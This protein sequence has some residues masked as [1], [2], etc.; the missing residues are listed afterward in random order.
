VDFSW[1]FHITFWQ[2][3]VLLYMLSVLYLLFQ[4]NYP[5]EGREGQAMSSAM[6]IYQSLS[7]WPWVIFFHH[8]SDQET[9]PE[10]RS[11]LPIGGFGANALSQQPW[12]ATETRVSWTE[13]A[14]KRHWVPQ[15]MGGFAPKHLYN[16]GTPKWRFPSGNLF[17]NHLLSDSI[18]V[19]GRVDNLKHDQPICGS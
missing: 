1:F 6:V 14:L 17:S 12:N 16:F 18:L 5:S 10:W 3:T 13:M 4:V 19:F 2:L 8:R 7:Q 11:E 15:L 9:S